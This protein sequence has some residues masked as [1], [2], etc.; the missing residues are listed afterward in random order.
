[1]LRELAQN[2]STEFTEGGDFAGLDDQE[3]MD[4]TDNEVRS[5]Q[6]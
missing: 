6:D 4:C 2:E 3:D 1:M 5:V